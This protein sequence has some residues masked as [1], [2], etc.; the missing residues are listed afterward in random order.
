MAAGA[1]GRLGHLLAVAAQAVAA[2][3][4]CGPDAGEAADRQWQEIKRAVAKK[5][6]R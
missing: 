3:A 5:R 2:A 6:K 4:T 1:G